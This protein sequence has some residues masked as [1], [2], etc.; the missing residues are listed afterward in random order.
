MAYHSCLS[1]HDTIEC[2]YYLTPGYDGTI[3]YE[4]LA[5]EKE[6]LRSAKVRRPKAIQLGNEEFLL[7]PNGTKSAFPFLIENDS[8]S[9]MATPLPYPLP[10]RP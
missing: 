8:F 3:N 2:A 5:A 7:M 10:C 9:K 4:R 6:A 1:C